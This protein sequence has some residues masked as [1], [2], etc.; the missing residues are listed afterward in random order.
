MRRFVVVPCFNEAQRLQLSGFEPFAEAEV[1]VL[2]VDDGSR[3][4]TTDLLEKFV[5]EHPSVRPCFD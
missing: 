4:E 1:H 3:D 5:R 2:F